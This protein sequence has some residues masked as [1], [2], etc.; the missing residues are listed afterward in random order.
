VARCE[1]T[2]ARGWMQCR[3]ESLDLGCA[4]SRPTRERRERRLTR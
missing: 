1:T 2:R 4:F 3:V